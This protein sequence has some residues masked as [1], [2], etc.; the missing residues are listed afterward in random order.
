MNRSEQF[1]HDRLSAISADNPNE[2]MY[3]AGVAAFSEELA[4]AVGLMIGESGAPHAHASFLSHLECKLA[5]IRTGVPQ[6]IRVTPAAT[7]EATTQA[8]EPATVR[9]S[10]GE[11]FFPDWPPFEKQTELLQDPINP[12]IQ[13]G[14]QY[15]TAAQLKDARKSKGLF[16]SAV[17]DL[18]EVPQWFISRLERGD[19][20]GI[21]QLYERLRAVLDIPLEVCDG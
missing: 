15:L 18:I 6:E 2:F 14:P 21:P 1:V 12:A 20:V 4:K 13:P 7:A 17:A 16:Q 19:R 9:R 3:G 10:P 5:D 11:W 8:T